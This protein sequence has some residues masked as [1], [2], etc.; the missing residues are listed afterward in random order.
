MRKTVC[1]TLAAGAAVTVIGAVT[2]FTSTAA[3]AETT[4]LIM[5]GSGLGNPVVTTD[6]GLTIP[7]PNYMPNVEKY[8]IAPNSSCKPES[9]QLVPVVTPEGLLPPIIGNTT[10]DVS[11]AQGVSDL[12]TA[13]DNQLA[14]DPK[15]KVVIFGY[16]QS[17]DIVT[18]TLRNFAAD[19]ASAPSPKQVSFVVIGNTNRPN[20]GIL[21]RFPGLYIP[22]LNVTFDGAAP[23]D[24]G[25]HTTD[26]AFEYDPVADFPEYPVDLLSDVN[27]LAAI[28]EVHATYP[29]PY[30]PIPSIPFFPTDIPD[31]YTPAELQQAM[32]DP[33]NRQVYGDTTFITIPAKNLPM[34][35][36]LLQIGA[37]TGTSFLTQPIVDL[38]QPALRVLVDLG[39]DRTV[40]YGQ[41]TPAGLFPTINPATLASQLQVAVSQGVQQ[42]LADIGIQLATATK[43]AVSAAATSGRAGAASA[44]ATAQQARRTSSTP[45]PTA[46]VAENASGA[47]KTGPTA[48]V[49]TGADK[50]PT[51]GPAKDNRSQVAG[52][53]VD[54]F[55][56]K[57][58]STGTGDS[59]HAKASTGTHAVTQRHH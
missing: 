33:A 3:M 13:L 38:V 5:G 54:K 18:K 17:G 32:T 39:Y 51:S 49:G 29:N 25:Y 37:A 19:P 48:S 58:Q 31:E 42:A 27:A 47:T 52:T 20:G 1:A 21:S 41:A 34:L 12:S 9:C 40:P 24:T 26:I 8:Y 11:V 22:I 6:A 23:T 55:L 53:V 16:S 43:A 28:F 46:T 4:A 7:I 14:T 10:F 45:A 56:K 35:E 44:Q 2:A 36:P 59:S 57:D 30:L 15:G 50:T